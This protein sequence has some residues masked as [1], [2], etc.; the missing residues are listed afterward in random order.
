MSPELAGA[1]AVGILLFLMFFGLPIWISMILVGSIGLSILNGPDKVLSMIGTWVLP[2]VS[3]PTFS[4][5]PIFLLMG[6]FADMSGMLRDAYRSA[7]ILLGAL[8]GG[9]AMASVVGAAA[10]SLVSGSSMACSA[11]MSRVALPQLLEHKYDPELA[12]GS[13][14]AGGTLGNLIPPGV[15]L[16]VY[17][18][19]TESSLSKLFVACYIPGFILASMYMV[20][21]YI[22]CKI[23]P[24]KGPSAGGSTWKDKLFAIKGLI[25][26]FVVFAVTL[27][28]MQSGIFTPNEAASICTVFVFIFAL[29]RRSLNGQ[30]LHAAFKNTLVTTGM[31]LGIL[32]G[33]RIFNVYIALSGLS[34]MLASWLI[35][36]NVSKLTLIILIMVVY[37]IMGIPMNGMTILMLTL[38]ILLPLLKAYQVDLTWFGVLAIAQCELANLSPPVGLNLFVVAAI[39]KPKGISMGTVFR[40]ALPFTVTCTVFI[41]LIIAFPQ[42]A[43]FLVNKMG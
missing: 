7:N 26:V 24:S 28:G 32:V 41:A 3:D 25:A 19:L 6:E 30:N 20:Q 21:I 13:L 16:V 33:A 15:L 35:E 29:I 9:L 14:A 12:T 27:G 42:I 39:A 36:L 34:Q 10:F 38:P 23:N 37:F 4:V 2:T 18:I 40:G 31:A 22:Q 1:I 8:R 17:A 43:M 11:L 5:M